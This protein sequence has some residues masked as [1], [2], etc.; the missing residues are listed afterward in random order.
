VIFI[1]LYVHAFIAERVGG[2]FAYSW[3]KT[4]YDPATDLLDVSVSHD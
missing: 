3:L 2:Q 1:I 4:K